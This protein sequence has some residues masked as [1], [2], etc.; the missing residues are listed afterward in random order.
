MAS[1][2]D[3][4][5]DLHQDSKQANNVCFESNISSSVNVAEMRDAT[6]QTIS[7]NNNNIII[8]LFMIV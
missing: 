1:Q 5:Y 3:V 6:T 2:L 4:T 8:P 7:S